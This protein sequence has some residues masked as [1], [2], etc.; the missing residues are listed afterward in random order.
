MLHKTISIEL[1]QIFGD[2]IIDR[3]SNDSITRI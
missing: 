3:F 2:K 1:E